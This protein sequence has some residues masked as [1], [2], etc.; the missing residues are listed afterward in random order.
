MFTVLGKKLRK[1]QLE[2]SEQDKRK[3]RRSPGW[4][5]KS[6]QFYKLERQVS[7]NF[8]VSWRSE[9]EVSSLA[10]VF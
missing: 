10:E 8:L 7:S 3:I 5:V 1:K 4:L 9:V 2:K 6:L